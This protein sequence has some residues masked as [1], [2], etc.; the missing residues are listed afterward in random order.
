[1][2]TSDEHP[3]QEQGSSLQR[4]GTDLRDRLPQIL[5]LAVLVIAASLR[6][7]GLSWDE[8]THLHPDERFLSMVETSIQFPS[9]LGE[10]FNT[11]VSPFNPHNVGHGFFVYG[12]LPIFI[13][14]YVGEWVGKT[15]YGEIHIVGRAVSTMFD[16]VSILLVYL[17]GTRLYRRRV[18]L[19][20][21]FFVALSVLLIQHA[22][23]FVVDS[24]ANT[25]ILAGFYFAVRVLD[26]GDIYDYLLF[27]LAL[28]MSVASKINAVPL[29]GV[30]AL[31][32]LVRI[33]R[34]A[35]EV[36]VRELYRVSLY[37]VAA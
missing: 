35:P 6:L 31:A 23:F 3:A 16:L 26:E 32:G 25:F 34:A 19:L 13:V 17:I 37:L 21:S 30:V 12:T 4:I 24:I 14:R 33:C 2:Q 20:A 22:H 28:G 9:S 7:I 5:L 10:Y 15:G 36:R 27:G 29:A 8:G 1:M 18:A 11:D